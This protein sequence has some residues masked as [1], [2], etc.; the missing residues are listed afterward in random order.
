MRVR[1]DEWNGKNLK[2]GAVGVPLLTLHVLHHHVGG[3]QLDHV[4]R[5]GSLVLLTVLQTLVEI[6]WKRPESV[7]VDGS[8]YIL[9]VDMGNVG[10]LE[11]R[12]R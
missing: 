8:N 3:Q 1:P 4:D 2:E 5:L 11:E 10:R 9:V 6:S 12:P 7:R